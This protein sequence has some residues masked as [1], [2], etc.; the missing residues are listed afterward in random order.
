MLSLGEQQRMGMARLFYHSP[1][2]AVLDE[3]TSAVSIDIEEKMY[4]T[5]RAGAAAA[6]RALPLCVCVRGDCGQLRVSIGPRAHCPRLVPLGL[7]QAHKK[8]I[9]CV[10]ISQRLALEH[11]HAAELQLGANNANGWTLRDIAGGGKTLPTFDDFDTNHDGVI[12]R[13]EFADAMRAQH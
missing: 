7:P 9:T 10:T 5:A 12:D 1:A 13:E 11:W 3:C 8:G 6:V 4:A 2:F